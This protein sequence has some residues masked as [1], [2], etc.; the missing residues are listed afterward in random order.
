KK[1]VHK[2]PFTNIPVYVWI[3]LGLGFVII[4]GILNIRG[5]FATS[6]QSEINRIGSIATWKDFHS[7]PSITSCGHR[8]PTTLGDFTYLNFCDKMTGAYGVLKFADKSNL[9][10]IADDLVD[11]GWRIQDTQYFDKTTKEMKVLVHDEIHDDLV[12]KISPDY[13][14]SMSMI[15]GSVV[16]TIDV[17][18]PESLE[19]NSRHLDTIG[20]SRVDL[21]TITQDQIL[22]VFGFDDEYVE[23]R[24]LP[25]A[26]FPSND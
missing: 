16:M 10:A 19:L 6:A 24:S 14:L 11:H 8:A 12:Q 22:V 2:S 20:L 21:P 5:V 17:A 26:I 25:F 13:A 15:R 4:F 3:I 1:P 9:Y 18:D 7:T 23:N